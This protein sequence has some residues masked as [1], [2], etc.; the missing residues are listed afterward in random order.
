MTLE[1]VHSGAEQR[2]AADFVLLLTGYEM[3]KQ[4]LVQMGVALEGIDQSPRVNL[5]TMESNLPG[6]FIAGTAVAGTQ[7]E[8]RLFIENCHPHV[9]RIVRAVTGQAPPFATSDPSKAVR[10]LPES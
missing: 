3:D 9:G 5:E 8:F 4:L 1:D 6:L 2:V 10:N 7:R